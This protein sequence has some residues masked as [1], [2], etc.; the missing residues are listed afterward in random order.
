MSYNY[1]EPQ[2][3]NDYNHN[4]KTQHSTIYKILLQHILSSW[5][6]YIVNMR[7]DINIDFEWII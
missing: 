5:I 2:S 3:L 7:P 4:P 1:M 6:I